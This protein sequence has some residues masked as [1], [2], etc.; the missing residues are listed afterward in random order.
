[1]SYQEGD[2]KSPVLVGMFIY[3]VSYNETMYMNL[4]TPPALFVIN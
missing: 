4:S 2:I 1:M 3:V